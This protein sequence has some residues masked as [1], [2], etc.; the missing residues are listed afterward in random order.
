MADVPTALEAAE[1]EEQK[2]ILRAVLNATEIGKPFFTSPGVPAERV[3][4][5]RRAFDKVVKDPEFVAE[6][7]KARVDLFPMTGENLQ[8]LV[9]ELGKIPPELIAK[10]K[11]NYGG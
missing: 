6:F 5:L 9:E 7:A 1:T 3:E 8:K 10:V 2:A 11:A 4:A